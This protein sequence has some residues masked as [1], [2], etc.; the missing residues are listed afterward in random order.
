VTLSKPLMYEQTIVL[1]KV[2]EDS[3]KITLV[4]TVVKRDLSL[5]P[6]FL[7]QSGSEQLSA[8]WKYCALRR[9]GLIHENDSLKIGIDQVQDEK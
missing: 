1:G 5:F 9:K 7:N 3:E 6:A 8:R 4:D 2:L